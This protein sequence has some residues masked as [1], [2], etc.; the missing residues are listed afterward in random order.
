MIVVDTSALLA[1]LF[2]EPAARACRDVLAVEREISISAGTL[3][4]ALILAAHRN[5]L[6]EMSALV[7]DLGIAIEPLDAARAR[8]VALA[9]KRWGKGVHPAGLNF[10]DCFAYSLAKEMDCPLLFLGEDFSR[11]DV[12]TVLG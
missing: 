6:E 11:T 8:R 7:E 1:I 2:A 9:H 12:K 4:E 5:A 10:G 3:S